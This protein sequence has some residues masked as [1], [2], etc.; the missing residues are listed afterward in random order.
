MTPHV[1]VCLIARILMV[2][3]TVEIVALCK[4]FTS[5]LTMVIFE[6]Q[7]VFLKVLKNLPN[8]FLGNCYTELSTTHYCDHSNGGYPTYC[9]KN[10]QSNCQ[11]QCDQWASCVGY[12]VSLN[13]PLY[14]NIFPSDGLCPAGW[15]TYS[16]TLAT[17]AEQLVAGTTADYTCYRITRK[18][19]IF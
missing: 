12:S 10:P 6:Y 3:L 9:T 5:K 2:G 14:C 11:Q 18:H 15:T 19:Q 1:N 4:V 13:N 8:Y 7:Y 16:H 17:T